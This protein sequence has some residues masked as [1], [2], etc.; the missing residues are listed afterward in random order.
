MKHFAQMRKN[1][2]ETNGKVFDEP[3]K[4]KIFAA[5]HKSTMKFYCPNKPC[6]VHS[7]SPPSS[8]PSSLNSIQ[9]RF[10]SC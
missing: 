9:P 6:E 4:I 2:S 7:C 10:K 3:L 1:W 5:V 8:G